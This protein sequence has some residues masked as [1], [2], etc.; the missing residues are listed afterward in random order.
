MIKRKRLLN[1]SV[2]LGIWAM[3]GFSLFAQNTPNLET[4]YLKMRDL[5]QSGKY[6]Q[7]KQEGLKLLAQ[8]PDY[9]DVS[10]MMGRIYMW[11]QKYD[12][13]GVVINDVLQKMPANTDAV[14]AKYD[15]AFFTG[16][17]ADVVAM[18][19]TL[20][21]QN[22]SRIDMMEKYALANQALGNRDKAVE[23][24]KNI[25][26]VDPENKVALSILHPQNQHETPLNIK[27]TE[28]YGTYA[29]DSF[30]KPYS[31]WWDLY[32]AG[33]LKPVSWGSVGGRVN[34]GH[35]SSD[36][37]KATEVQVEAETY[38]N[39]TS[40]IYMYALYGYS[41]GMPYF[42]SHKAALE[43]WHKLPAAMIVSAGG[44][45]YR[46]HDD[47]FIATA[48]LEKYAGNYWF[49]LR[50]YAQFKEIGISP[51]VYFTARRYF[52]DIDYFQATVGYGAAP[53]EPF[54][55]AYAS[56]RQTAYSLRVA[57]LKRLSERFKLRAGI[58]YAYEEY[59]NE[60]YRNRFDGHISLIYAI[61][62]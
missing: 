19:D 16:K 60:K 4:Q 5:A 41:D 50:G 43:F 27:R 17:M 28:V 6:L 33:I 13:A 34:V 55:I 59:A 61:G 56:E 10:V 9:Y 54:D 53:D 22:P 24:A 8:K 51:S 1:I 11:E 57:G 2:P 30:E 42:P 46:W 45:Y 48:S 7:A 26:A 25:L 29:F 21:A 15:L 62:K 52:N 37:D 12:S 40:Q 31:R 47:I 38:I 20:I 39:L 14:E 18:G 49:C 58:G 32:T 44:S 3:T 36:F 35:L 23:V